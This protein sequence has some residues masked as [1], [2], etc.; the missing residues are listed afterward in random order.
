MDERAYQ[1]PFCFLPNCLLCTPP[2]IPRP[3]HLLRTAPIT[4]HLG[5]NHSHARPSATRGS[6]PAPEPQQPLTP[7]PPAPR[8]PSSPQVPKSG[9]GKKGSRP[10]NRDRF[11]SKMFLRGDS[12]ILVL[13]NPK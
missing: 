6:A 9:R 10:V 5:S 12:V 1:R 11:V 8:A 7:H 2:R 13:R 4:P 3:L